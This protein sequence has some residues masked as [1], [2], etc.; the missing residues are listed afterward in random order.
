MNNFPFVFSK[1]L[2]FIQYY[3]ILQYYTMEHTKY[4][5]DVHCSTEQDYIQK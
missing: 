4:T 2:S 1:Y 5:L 3:V